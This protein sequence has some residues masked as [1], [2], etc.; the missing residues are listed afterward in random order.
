M[1][2]L[3]RNTDFFFG[4]VHPIA[5]GDIRRRIAI[6]G[7]ATAE[8]PALESAESAVESRFSGPPESAPGDLE[9]G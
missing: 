3:I 2:E 6:S 9:K 5:D 8:N 1:T 7:A 4:D